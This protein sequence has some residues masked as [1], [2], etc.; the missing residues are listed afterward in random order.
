[1][2]HLGVQL[3]M[4]VYELAKIFCS[5][6]LLCLLSSFYSW[7]SCSAVGSHVF[8]Y[9]QAVPADSA[10]CQSGSVFNAILYSQVICSS[11]L[12]F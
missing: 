8:V 2:Q 7:L 11:V 1:M 6:V 12:P 4:F 5:E 9:H 3:E 10:F